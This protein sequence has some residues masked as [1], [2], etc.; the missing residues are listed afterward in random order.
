MR[1]PFST[2]AV[3]YKIDIANKLCN[4]ER[5]KKME[6]FKRD[7]KIMRAIDR[8]GFAILA[9]VLFGLSDGASP[10]D[11]LT[12]IF[13]QVMIGIMAVA[14]VLLVSMDL[15]EFM[16]NNFKPGVNRIPLNDS[17]FY[18]DESDYDCDDSIEDYYDN[19]A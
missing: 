10:E 11:M 8:L 4:K 17:D 12:K 19:I 1:V 9:M 15:F 6:F 13:I 16:E 5:V 2:L 7:N 14:L 3:L 18:D